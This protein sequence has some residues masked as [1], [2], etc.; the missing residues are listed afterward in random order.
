[1]KHVVSFKPPFRVDVINIWSLI[2]LLQDA[3][4]IILQSAIAKCII[5]KLLLVLFYTAIYRVME[6]VF[7]L[8]VSLRWH[9]SLSN[10]MAN[11]CHLT[12]KEGPVLNCIDLKIM[13]KMFSPRSNVVRATIVLNELIIQSSNSAFKFRLCKR[14]CE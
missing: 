13:K 1:M 10:T 4:S 3:S 7:K 8:R 2:M 11:Y 6:K 14:H 5:F 9:I 12:E